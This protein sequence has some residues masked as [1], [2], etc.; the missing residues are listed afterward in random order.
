MSPEHTAG[1]LERVVVGAV[2][3]TARALTQATPDV[4]L[5]FPQWRALLI[6]GEAEDGA[7]IS[8]VADRVGVTL[9]APGRLLRRLE[10]RGLVKLAVDETDRRA[11][12][13]R[14]TQRGGQ[15]RADILG[16]R[17]E[18]LLEIAGRLGGDADAAL[19]RTA[20]ALREFA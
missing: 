3:L 2:G 9:P 14:L 19:E 7:R 16:F 1:L 5:T 20:E 11:T 13:A 12:R 8:T 4:E 6:L 15:V 18:V 17:R 10:A